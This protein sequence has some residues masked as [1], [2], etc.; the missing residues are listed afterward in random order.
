MTIL[1][2]AK[3][4]LRNGAPV[5]DLKFGKNQFAALSS[6]G[7]LNASSNQDLLVQMGKF[8]QA[9]ASGEIVQQAEGSQ[10]A[11]LSNE[12]KRDLLVKAHAS[13]TEWAALGAAIAEDVREQASRQGFLRNVCVVNNLRQGEVMRVPMPRHISRA[14]VA[15]GPT[16]VAYQLVTDR[17][18]IPSP[19]ELKAAV[20]VSKL[21]LATASHDLLDRAYNDSIEAIVTAGDRVWKR[22]ADRTVGQSNAIQGFAGRLTPAILSRAATSIRDWNLPVSKA[23]IANSFWEDVQSDSSWADS[24]TPVSQ[25][26]LLLTGKVGTIF[27]LEIMTDGFRA[28]NQRV[29]GRGEAYIVADAEYHGTMGSFGGIESTPTDGA[30]A[31]ETSKGWLMSE[32]MSLVIPNT[33]SVVKLQKL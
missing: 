11:S 1:R 8:F 7:E 26:E 3:F 32:I 31:G 22:A 14:V 4:G 10:F 33:R 17:Q 30:N 29:L 9:M 18:F 2:G 21:D 13:Q 27:G 20:R 15:T 28:D 25:Y 24:L 12:E 23:I 16:S 5:S 6:N 19:F